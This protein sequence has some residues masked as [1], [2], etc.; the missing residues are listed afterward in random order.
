MPP[1][2]SRESRGEGGARSS[3]HGAGQH[4]DYSWGYNPSTGRYMAP[5]T[6]ISSAQPQHLTSHQQ[7]QQEHL[8]PSAYYSG[9]H[10]RPQQ[11]SHQHQQQI[12]PSI[13]SPSSGTYSWPPSASFASS[14]GTSTAGL[15]W[16]YAA[17]QT[18]Q[19]S[20]PVSERGGDRVSSPPP[21]CRTTAESD[22][23]DEQL[24]FE[25]EHGIDHA[26]EED[27]EDEN[28]RPLSGAG[29][30]RQGGKKRRDRQLEA[31]DK[32]GT[33]QSHAQGDNQD[34]GKGGQRKRRKR[35]ILSCTE[36]KVSSNGY[37]SGLR[38]GPKRRDAHAYTGPRP[39]VYQ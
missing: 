16:N 39:L 20:D 11:L 13:P 18:Y 7:P 28:A 8:P 17:S 3:E 4:P 35:A 23:L 27:E 9:A 38:L 31:A 25:Q 32:G 36:C 34:M 6:R 37:V 14:S 30:E 33:A 12:Y 24:E 2:K 10:G 29:D 19:G 15:P 5:A 22:Q 26:T 21:S 1:S